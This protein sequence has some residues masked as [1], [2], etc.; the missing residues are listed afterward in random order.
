M[1]KQVDV[2]IISEGTYP[3]VRGGVSS[4][5][6]DLISSISELNF[7]IV[8]LGSLRSEY[9][10]L[11]YELP[12]NVVYLD[13]N[14]LFEHE[15]FPPKETIT[16]VKDFESIVKMHQFFKIGKNIPPQIEKLDF[17]ENTASLKNFLYSFPSWEF[18]QQNYIKNANNSPFI[19]YF[20]SVKNMHI[21]IWRLIKVARKVEDFKIVHSPSTG[22]A[23]FLAALLGKN[24]NKPFILTEHGIY[25]KERKIDLLNS[26]IFNENKGLLNKALGEIS[27]NKTMWIK[28]FEGLGKFTYQSAEKII[29]LFEG[30]RKVQLT[31]GAPEEKTMVI[32]NGIDVKKLEKL[33]KEEIPKVV[34]L[35][36]RVVPIKDI[37][38][39]IKAMKIATDKMPELEGWIVG[40]M[41]EDPEYANECQ[42]LVK[43]LNLEEKVK[44]LGF[45]KI[46]DI[47][48]KS[49]LLTLTSISEGMPLVV[50]EGFAAGLPAVTTDVG[51]CSELIYGSNEEDKLIGQAGEVVEIANPTAI[52]NAYIKL[53]SD[54][55]FYKKCQKSAIK[56]VNT[57]YTKEKFIQ[58]YKE[59]YKEYL[60]QE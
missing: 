37:K 46:T 56:R 43:S 10:E 23:G 41:D 18:I 50:I 35:I 26:T 20:W 7:G 24:Y 27:Y 31:Y 2:L 4:W 47:L 14:Y 38:T 59:I 54:E 29:S 6:H 60:W 19:D 30:A 1:K 44:F 49:G 5:I 53:L 15:D 3:Y 48:P 36:G 12:P 55:E 11:K 51:S 8:F 9:K 57:Y 28:F 40:P 13:T 16:S 21:P 17:Y 33:Q 58:N 52:A 22:Y 32:P 42:L 34:T 45:Q 39:F 25:I